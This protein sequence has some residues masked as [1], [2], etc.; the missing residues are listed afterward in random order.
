MFTSAS[1]LTSAQFGAIPATASSTS[2][3]TAGYGPAAVHYLSASGR[4]LDTASPAGTGTPVQ[5]NIDV[6]D[7]DR[8]GNTVRTLDATNRLLALG[9]GP[10]AAAGLAEL[11][12]TGV[13]NTAGRAGTVLAGPLQRRRPGPDQ[14]HR[15]GA[16]PGD[17]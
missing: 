14:H 1:N 16:A 8:F 10:T 2:P 7:Y 13:S 4:E 15:A 11:G 17:R 12:L 5:G 3:G 9:V 6:A